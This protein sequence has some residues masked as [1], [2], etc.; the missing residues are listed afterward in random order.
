MTSRAP[1]ARAPAAVKIRSICAP[2]FC[3]GR[4]PGGPSLPDAARAGK[5]PAAAPPRPIHCLPSDFI[6]SIMAVPAHERGRPGGAA[7]LTRRGLAMVRRE[8]PGVALKRCDLSRVLE[9]VDWAARR[10][11]AARLGQALDVVELGVDD[12]VA[13]VEQHV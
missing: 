3:C 11:S 5:P 12:V 9:E 2:L 10:A 13:V 8:S 6:M 7:S 1:A 4:E